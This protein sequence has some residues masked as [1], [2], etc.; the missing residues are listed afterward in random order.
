M[1]DDNKEQSSQCVNEGWWFQYLS[2]EEK[3]EQQKAAGLLSVEAVPNEPEQTRTG[4]N[5]IENRIVKHMRKHAA[6]LAMVVG[7]TSVVVHW[8]IVN[9][10]LHKLEKVHL[11]T[12][13]TLVNSEEKV[14][15]ERDL[16]AQTSKTLENE[17]SLVA[18]IE[19]ELVLS[20]QQMEKQNKELAVELDRWR[21]SLGKVVMLAQEVYA[22]KIEARHGSLM[23]LESEK[24]R[25]DKIRNLW[26]EI[27]E[28]LKNYDEFQRER[29]LIQLRVIQS[30]AL[31]GKFHQLELDSIDWKTADME[32]ERPMLLTRIYYKQAKN[33]LSTG[34]NVEAVAL[35]QSCMKLVKEIDQGRGEQSYTL[36]MLSELSGD[37]SLKEQPKDAVKSYLSAIEAL[38]EVI[39]EVPTNAELRNKLAQLCQDLSVVP[40]VEGNSDWGDKLKRE[41]HKQATWLVKRYPERKSA[42]LIL[43]KLD[44]NAAEESLRD[45]ELA[46]VD[47][48]LERS[49]QSLKRGGDD[50]VMQ[51]WIEGMRAFMAWDKGYRTSAMKLMNSQISKLVKFVESDPKNTAARSRCAALLWVR[52]MMQLSVDKA[53]PDGLEALEYLSTVFSGPGSLH[54]M[55]AR[56]M[57]AIILCDLAEIEIESGSKNKARDYL[58]RAQRLWGEMRRKWGVPDEDRELQHW[59]TH[60]LTLL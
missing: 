51:S 8:G 4:W 7:I 37:L 41:A 60:Q 32:Q 29:A 58:I 49:H 27:A 36:A 31:S 42:H 2:E 13:E 5:F 56:R 46:K 3:L 39:S 34:R 47:D 52:S 12:L 16:V 26:T 50:V 20:R 33:L 22:L 18:E 38:R 59:C 23:D 21:A 45:G 19:A 11:R 54:E 48:L 17:K 9:F 14:D 40:P 25:E 15:F 43:A 53:R 6:K 10:R 30:Q 28:G 24:T 57:S 55:S 35:V 1:N 44:I